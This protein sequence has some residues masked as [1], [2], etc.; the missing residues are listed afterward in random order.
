M[1]KVKSRYLA[2][3]AGAAL[4][5]FG[6]AYTSSWEGRRLVAYLDSGGVPTICDGHT[7][8][9]VR[10]GMKATDAECDAILRKDI[11][12]HESRM[13]SCAPELLRVPDKSYVAINDWAFNVGTGAAC[14]STLIDKVKA[15][16]IRGACEQLSR[17]V[18]VKGK[19]ITGLKNRR[20]TGTPGRISERALCLAGL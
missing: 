10:L 1:A 8:P 15:G 14:K 9:E 19:V 17:W 18:F 2:G 6:T 3:A 4:L 5:T 20:V 11:L 13:L 7:G 12:A 16:D